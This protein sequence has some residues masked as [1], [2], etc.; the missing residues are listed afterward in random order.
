MSLTDPISMVPAF[1]EA[2]GMSVDNVEG[3]RLTVRVPYAEH[4]VGDPD[5]GVIHGGVI[6]AA[7]DNASGWAIRVGG[8]W[9]EGMSMATLDLRIDYMK[10]ATPNEDLLV[11]AECFKETKTI[12]FVRATAYQDSPDDPVATSIAAFMKGTPNEPRR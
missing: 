4:L 3:S 11:T 10:P 12:A 9:E 7:L 5:T 6:T 1:G 8:E 2:I